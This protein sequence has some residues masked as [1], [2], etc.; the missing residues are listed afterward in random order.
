MTADGVLVTGAT[1]F[2]GRHLV[3]GLLDRGFRVF[4]LTRAAN[5]SPAG[6]RLAGALQSA[7]GRPLSEQFRSRLEPLEGD[8]VKPDLGLHES[9]KRRLA[10]EVTQVFHCGGDTRFFPKDRAA[11]RAVH[12]DGPLNLL[13]TIDQGRGVRFHHVSTAYVAGRRSGTAFEDELAVGQSF[14]NPYERI[15]LEAEQLITSACEAR[16]IGLTIFRP[17]IVIA[18]P[19]MPNAEWADPISTRFAG[20]AR[21]C[22]LYKRTVGRIRAL[23][24]SLRVRG[25]GKSALNVVPITYV[26]EAMLAIAANGPMS[27]GTFHLV[28]PAPPRNQELLDRITEFFGLRGLEPFEHRT[29]PIEEASL[30]ERVVENLLRPYQDY[31]FDSPTFDDRRARRLLDGV[32]EPRSATALEF[33][34]RA[35]DTSPRKKSRGASRLVDQKGEGILPQATDL[36]P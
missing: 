29:L 6:D 11:Y 36:F 30:L 25:S 12:L 34:V 3:L 31:F 19:L 14:R 33:L 15:K 27:L 28:D 8:L 7:H 1:G 17:S 32:V 4:A 22:G 21:L 5:G 13:R 26:V 18:D 24:P 9:T 16:E 35:A 10:A 23:R 2:I 20:F